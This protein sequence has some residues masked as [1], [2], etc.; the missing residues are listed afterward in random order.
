VDQLAAAAG[1]L[2]DALKDWAWCQAQRR[3]REWPRALAVRFALR[4]GKAAGY[5][6]GWRHYRRD[7]MATP[8]IAS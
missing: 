3:R 5:R 7:R 1:A 2:R 8:V 4:L 6:A